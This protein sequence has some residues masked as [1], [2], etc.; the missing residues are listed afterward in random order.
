MNKGMNIRIAMVGDVSVVYIDGNILQENAPIFKM[1]LLDLVKKGKVNIVLNMGSSNFISSM[2]LATIAEVKR[3]VSDI[4]GNLKLACL[5]NL[6]QNLL[7]ATNLIK[8]IET[9]EDLDVAV[10]SFAM[11]KK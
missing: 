8:V 5:N 7:E 2:C 1:K 11:T 10:K 4:G 9:F 3:K 6:V